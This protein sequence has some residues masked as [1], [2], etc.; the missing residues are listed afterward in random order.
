MPK[1][2]FVLSEV[3][4][5]KIIISSLIGRSA[6]QPQEFRDI[7]AASLTKHTSLVI[8]HPV[9]LLRALSMKFSLYPF[10]LPFAELFLYN[11]V[12]G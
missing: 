12:S 10:M 5:Q 1:G 6:N 7:Q 4:I 9:S 8:Y 11:I 2:L 3:L